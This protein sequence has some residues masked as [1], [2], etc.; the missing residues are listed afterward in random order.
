MELLFVYGILRGA[1]QSIATGIAI[2]ATMHDLGPYPAISAIG[3]G[4][5][6]IG[7]LIRVS[8]EDLVEFDIIEGVPTLYRRGCVFVP[9][10]GL[11]YIYIYQG[12]VEGFPLIREWGVL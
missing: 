3:T 12:S 1:Q 10:I 5:A 11:A 7:D 8:P 4:D 6:A 2:D 9:G